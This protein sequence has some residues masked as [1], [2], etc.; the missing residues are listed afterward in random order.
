MKAKIRGSLSEMS[1]RFCKRLCAPQA[2]LQFAVLTA[3]T[4]KLGTL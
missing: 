4:G 1:I 3:G 2:P